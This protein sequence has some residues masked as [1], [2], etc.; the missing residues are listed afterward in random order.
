MARNNV[1]LLNL[2]N[3]KYHSLAVELIPAKN[4]KKKLK[5]KNILQM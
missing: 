2:I 4:F 5:K 1:T 3:D